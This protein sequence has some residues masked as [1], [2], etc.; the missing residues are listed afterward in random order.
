[1]SMA[2]NESKSI[3]PESYP[4]KGLIIVTVVFDWVLYI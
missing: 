4:K 2:S 1:M 3:F